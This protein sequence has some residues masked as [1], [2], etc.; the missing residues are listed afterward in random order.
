M[1]ANESLPNSCFLKS[2][3][4]YFALLN[5]IDVLYALINF[6]SLFSCL[7]LLYFSISLISLFLFC[8]ELEEYT[9]MHVALLSE[10]EE[11]RWRFDKQNTHFL[12]DG[13]G[14]DNVG[15]S[16]TSFASA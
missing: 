10:Q 9:R 13:S 2:G 8:D 3:L 5:D 11:R 6:F 1:G 7:F 4:S 15:C 16:N 14:G 12:K